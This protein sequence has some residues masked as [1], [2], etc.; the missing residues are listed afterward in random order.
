MKRSILFFA[1]FLAS[2]SGLSAQRSASASMQISAT[3]VESSRLNVVSTDSGAQIVSSSLSEVMFTVNEQIAA[4]VTTE[5][6]ERR[7]AGRAAKVQEIRIDA[8]QESASRI[9]VVSAFY[10]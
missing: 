3:V 9:V 8:A 7:G 1:L 4:S 2:V 6:S 5:S 10:Q